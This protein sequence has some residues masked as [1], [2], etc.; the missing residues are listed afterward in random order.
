VESE[1]QYLR[2]K[3]TLLL[4]RE[5]ELFDLRMKLDQL[6]VWLSIGQALPELFLNRGASPDEVWSSVR[7][8]LV[9][10][11]RMQRV[12]LLEL[13]EEVLR[14]F[15]PAGPDRP[16]PEE[17]RVLLAAR[18]WGLCND[19][20]ADSSPP[21]VAALA[22]TL[23]LHQFMWSRIA[24]PQSSPILMVAGFDR[25][26]AAFQSPFVDN[27]AAHLSNAAQHLESLLANA[28]LVAELEREKDQL[29]QANKTLEQ[30]DQAL[31]EATE[32]LRA[33]NETL[34]RRVLERT[35]ELRQ[36]NTDLRNVFDAVNQGLVTIDRQAR[37]TGECSARAS[38]WFGSLSE[39]R[40]W[41]DALASV[42]STYAREFQSF[43][44]RLA[45]D[46]EPLASVRE[47]MPRKLTID[48]RALEID[49]SPVG[50]EASWS[51]MLVVV[52]DVS[53]RERQA[54][55]EMDLR[56][57]QKLHAVGEL[58]AGIA[59]EINTPAQFVGDSI[60]FLANAFE[61]TLALVGKYRGALQ[62]AG[63]ERLL[64]KMKEAEGAADLEY[65]QENAPG[66]WSRARDGVSRIA[67]IVRAMKEFS[68]PDSRQ[69][70]IADL[71]RAIE[72]TLTIA[73][74]EYKYVAEVQTA[75]GELPLV[76][77][78]VGDLNQVFLNLIVNS[79]HA[80]SDV[81]GRSGKMGRIVVRTSSEGDKVRIEIS[82]T[83]C[84]IPAEIRDRVFDPFFTTKE[85]GR[86]SGQGLAIARN[87]IVDKHG[88]TLTFKSEVGRGTTFT[89]LLP[90]DAGVAQAGYT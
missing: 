54:S 29:R 16:L 3:A 37:L 61:E 62:E 10:K 24:R 12:L 72:T 68:H 43:F 32:E 25:T 35:S 88:G 6:T 34:E 1:K 57:A 86:G 89:I 36:R 2:E 45:Q 27:D 44:T 90:V 14:A 30:R 79:A 56:Q 15:S 7:K 67:T 82:D 4:Q 41:I 9:V 39:G 63:D 49:L 20:K 73:R 58:A 85:V 42:D 81:V 11:L 18:P 76:H 8:T 26:K 52:S 78:H 71:N 80:I 66:A 65:T 33:A 50:G 28:L 74:N 75:L 84:G 55:L 69:K 53:D 38:A 59:H 46:N 64:A 51:R 60:E 19:P 5:R 87:V 40:S 22:E 70:A 13:H 31:Q 77:C 17:A 48:R 21:G 83:G 23:N 47:R